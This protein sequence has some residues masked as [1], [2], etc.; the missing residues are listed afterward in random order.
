MAVGMGRRDGFE[1]AGRIEIPMVGNPKTL[2]IRSQLDRAIGSVS[3]APNLRQIA[4]V[5]RSEFTPKDCQTLSEVLVVRS[6]GD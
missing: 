5:I 4:D 3:S 6:E 1:A 2:R